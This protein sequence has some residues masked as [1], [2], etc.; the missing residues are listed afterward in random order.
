M[1]AQP[2]MIVKPEDLVEVIG[3]LLFASAL[4]GF[5]GAIVF[6]LLQEIGSAMG[7]TI[8]STAWYNKRQAVMLHRLATSQSF[9]SHFPPHERESRAL[10]LLAKAG[11]YQHKATTI[12]ERKRWRAS[13]RQSL[14][15][16]EAS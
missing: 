13:R 5:A 1:D 2:L 11:Q 3:L 14:K 10:K 15:Q 16:G 8:R 6:R 7:S 12:E 4:A 9:L